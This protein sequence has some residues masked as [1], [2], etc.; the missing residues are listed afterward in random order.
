LTEDKKE[1]TPE[2]LKTFDGADGRPAYVAHR[3]RV[4][5]VSASTHWHGGR[6]MG[7][8]QAG[9]D[10]TREIE[11]AP[12]GPEVLEGFPEVGL[13]RIA[14]TGG[15]EIP[16][17]LSRLFH[18]IP[19]LRRHPHPMIV[20]FP[21]VFMMATA[22]FALLFPF[23]GDPSFEVT[24]WY[25]LWG[26]V[27]FTLPAIATGLFTWWINYDLEFLRPVVVK[28]IL[29]PVMLLLGSAALIWRYLD[30]DILVSSKPGSYL[31]LGCLLA[32]AGLVGAIGWFGGTLTFP[33]END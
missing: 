27:L 30:P 19:L 32:L 22:G 23:T 2:E 16:A 33:L 29:S 17:F 20:H 31:Y 3:D 15:K 10:L 24:S 26:G 12:H 4:I 14:Q 7:T 1:F 28:L 13:M 18:A 21:I 5:D 11:A 25:C 8:H 6:H 9:H